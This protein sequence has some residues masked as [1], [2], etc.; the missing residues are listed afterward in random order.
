MRS[1]LKLVVLAGAV[2]IGGAAS[3]SAA[4]TCSS[5]EK[6]SYAI[7]PSDGGDVFYKSFDDF[8]S[9]TY[10]FDE[11]SGLT[12]CQYCTGPLYCAPCPPPDPRGAEVYSFCC[13]PTKF[14]NKCY[15]IKC[16]GGGNSGPADT[17]N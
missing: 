10:V 8:Y 2:L 9:D 15:M 6:E 7:Y 4:Y 16:S 1:F 13:Q 17:L 11:T 12:S 3:A 5:D 14:G